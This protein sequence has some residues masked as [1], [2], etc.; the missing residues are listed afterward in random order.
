ML[1]L[2]AYS[3]HPVDAQEEDMDDRT[4]WPLLALLAFPLAG[5]LGTL[6]IA[7]RHWRYERRKR[8]NART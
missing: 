3:I 8:D 4:L 2:I 1:S 5:I 7:Y 6:D